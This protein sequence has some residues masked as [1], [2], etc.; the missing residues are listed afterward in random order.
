[1]YRTVYRGSRRRRQTTQVHRGDLRA[2]GDTE[3]GFALQCDKNDSIGVLT[4]LEAV[5]GK[6]AVDSE[7]MTAKVVLNYE[8]FPC[9]AWYRS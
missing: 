6:K 5:T 7:A 4:G 1:V 8:H 2:A 9:I 3:E